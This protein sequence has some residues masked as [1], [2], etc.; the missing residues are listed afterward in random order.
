MKCP[1]CHYEDTK[2]IDT[3]ISTD[4]SSI[5][6]RRKC[7]RCHHKF[8]TIETYSKSELI[9]T[10][11]NG[12][13]EEFNFDKIIHSLRKAIKVDALSDKKVEAATQII[14]QEIQQYPSGK[15]STEIIGQ[16]VM[17]ALKTVDPIAYLRFASIYKNFHET[18]EFEQEF[19]N[20]NPLN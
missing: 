2:V 17:N 5:R 9:V 10:K 11:R 20:L 18:H 4:Q 13:T 14:S 3:R 19:K 1:Q 7:L 15:I 12:L 6:R 8:S 16:I